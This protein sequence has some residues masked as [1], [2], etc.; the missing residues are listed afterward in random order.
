MKKISVASF[1]EEYNKLADDD[2]KAKYIKDKLEIKQ[3]IPF[4]EKDVAM[5]KIVDITMYE[6][7]DY[8][9][10]D[11]NALRK[12]TGNIK[13]DS[14]LQYL[15]LARTI[16]DCYTN[17]KTTDKFYAEYDELAQSGI[18][19]FITTSIPD[20]E[21][22]E[23]NIILDGKKSDAIT[24][25]YETHSFIASQIR[26]FGELGG[27]ILEPV[28]RKI[29]DSISNMDESQVERISDKFQTII[30]NFK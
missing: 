27:K 17:L 16:V 18:M 29:N 21:L 26:R 10:L 13:M 8:T 3:Y 28:M 15:L 7:E 30:K 11:G 25:T 14:T 22:N 6:R 23:L 12:K 24:N 4:L 2:L 1:C 19:D 5:S 9:D 20:R